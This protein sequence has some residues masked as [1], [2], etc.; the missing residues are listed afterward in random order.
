MINSRV[1]IHS[2]VVVGGR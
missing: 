1:P 2:I